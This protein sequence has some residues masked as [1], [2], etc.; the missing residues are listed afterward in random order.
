VDRGTLNGTTTNVLSPVLVRHSDLASHFLSDLF[1]LH[2]P[3]VVVR[4]KF[5]RLGVDN[6]RSR[7]Y[8][9]TC[10]P[11]L[12]YLLSIHITGKKKLE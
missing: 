2:F 5:Q 9:E 4:F 3:C 8:T 1:E 12:F 10:K 6:L 7:Q 11:G